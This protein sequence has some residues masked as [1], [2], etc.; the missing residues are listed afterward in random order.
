MEPEHN[1]TPD[2]FGECSRGGDLEPTIPHSHD[3]E[4]VR[5]GARFARK[6]AERPDDH[7]P[8]KKCAEFLSRPFADFSKKVMCS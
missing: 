2:G 5:G 6:R 1:M 7:N 4:L 8:P 3:W